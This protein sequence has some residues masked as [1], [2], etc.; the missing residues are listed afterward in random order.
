MKSQLNNALAFFQVVAIITN[1][2]TFAAAKI[3]IFLHTA[4]KFFNSRLA[5]T[6]PPPKKGYA[7]NAIRRC[8]PIASAST[9]RMPMNPDGDASNQPGVPTPGKRQHTHNKPRRGGRVAAH[10]LCRPHGA[11]L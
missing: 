9:D 10:P 8:M 7:G 2:S 5:D 6:R 11:T 4:K 3:H 1:L